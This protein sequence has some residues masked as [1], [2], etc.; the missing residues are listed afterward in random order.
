MRPL[1]T[2]WSSFIVLL[3]LALPFTGGCNRDESSTDDSD[4]MTVAFV[5]NQVASFWNI[6]K[7]GC[8]DA[9]KDLDINVDVRMPA[10][11]TAVE[12]KRVVEDLLASGIDGLAVSPIDA[13]NQQD[14]VNQWAKQVPLITQDSDAPGTDRLMYIGMDNY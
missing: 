10:P 1:R 13:D 12:Q 5:T 7:V 2:P 9:A 6:A 3:L 14:L 4:R 8:E 11:G